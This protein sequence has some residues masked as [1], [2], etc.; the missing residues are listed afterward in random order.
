M[1]A[2]ERPFSSDAPGVL[3]GAAPQP[4]AFNLEAPLGVKLLSPRVADRLRE[5]LS[6]GSAAAAGSREVKHADDLL[7]EHGLIRRAGVFRHSGDKVK[8][9]LS[10][11]L[12]VVDGCNLSCFY[13]YIPELQKSVTPEHVGF[14]RLV[15]DAQAANLIAD[16]LVSYCTAAKLG[17]L[18]VK[19]AGGEPTLVIELVDQFCETIYGAASDAGIIVTFSM[20]TN[21]VFEP[22]RVIPV[23]SRRRIRL[24]VS[25]DGLELDHDRIRFTRDSAGRRGTWHRIQANL[26]QL[27]SI[28]NK[29][30]FLLTITRKNCRDLDGFAHHVHGLGCGFRLSLERGARQPDFSHQQEMARLLADFYRHLADTAPL[31]SRFDRVARFAEWDLHRRKALTCSTCRSYV[32]IGRDGAVAS[33]QMRLDHPIGNV[34]TNSLAVLMERFSTRS[35]TAKLRRPGLKRGP[36]T[37]CEFRNVCAGGCPQHTAAVKGELDRTSP[38]CFVYGSLLPH[39]V[40]ACARHLSRRA[41]AA[42]EHVLASNAA[43]RI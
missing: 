30:Y 7:Y 25:L 15:M 21:A 6:T 5:H 41:R 38:W 1:T 36:C 8:L 33:C 34:R 23:L 14:G 26:D 28:G 27:L 4:W 37:Q 35:D 13:C 40:A 17:R 22:Q 20:L 43:G 16:R 32:A 19:F 2:D 3:T 24:G 18:N 9:S 29:P 11:W 10:V 42:K 31:T 12:N 39:Y